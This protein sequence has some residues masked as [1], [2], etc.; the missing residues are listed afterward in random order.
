MRVRL[1][2]ALLGVVLCPGL[3]VAQSIRV[4]HP[5]RNVRY[6]AGNQVLVRWTNVGNVPNTVKIALTCGDYSS[7]RVLSPQT[8]NDGQERVTL[9]GFQ[10]S[11]GCKIVVAALPLQAI[12]GWSEEFRVV[13]RSTG[14][15]PDLIGCLEWDGKRPYVQEHKTLMARVINVGLGPSAPSFFDIYQEGFGTHHIA[16]PSLAVGVGFNFP[17][18]LSWPSAGHKTVRLTVD[19]ANQIAE[20]NEAN[21][22]IEA[23][24]S[25]ILPG[26]D[27]HVP[28]TKVCSDRQ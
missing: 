20:T 10:E 4:D 5:D 21:N 1:D 2:L 28:E 22:Q 24:V 9:P 15:L 8:Q 12:A 19:P 14:G 26:Q 3:V 16:V 6:P 17:K 11:I 13:P 25:V 23:R 7:V 18:R 27:R